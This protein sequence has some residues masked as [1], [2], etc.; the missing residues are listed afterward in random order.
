MAHFRTLVEGKQRRDTHLSLVWDCPASFSP[1]RSGDLISLKC[2]AGRDF[3][4][5]TGLA[6]APLT[7]RQALYGRLG[8]TER[9]E[10]IKRAGHSDDINTAFDMGIQPPFGKY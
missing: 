6:H 8:V 2:V 1:Y 10:F 9:T 3:T 5:A 4:K 7:E